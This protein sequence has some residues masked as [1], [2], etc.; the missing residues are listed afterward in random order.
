MYNKETSDITLAVNYRP[1]TLLNTDYSRLLAKMLANRLNPVL[2][3]VISPEQTAYLEGRSVG[4]IMFLQ[5]LP[6]LMRD[7]GRTAVIPFLDF[8]KAYDTIDRAF[9]LQ[10]MEVMGAGAGFLTWV[11]TLLPPP[12]AAAVVNGFASA[13]VD[14]VAGVPGCP[15]RLSTLWWV[16]IAGVII[17]TIIIRVAGY[18]YVIRI[19]KR[20]RVRIRPCQEVCTCI[21]QR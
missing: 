15:P 11:R 12:Q 3:N 5:L 1:I 6:A 21:R 16:I 17:I 4:D 10:A 2:C 14:F 19:R 18:A 9:L 20:I 13:L 8:Y 7:E